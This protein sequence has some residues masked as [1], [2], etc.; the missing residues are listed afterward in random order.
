MS[1]MKFNWDKFQKKVKQ[2]SEKKKGYEKDDRFWQPTRDPKKGTGSAIIRFIP[3]F[4]YADPF[5]KMFSHGFYFMHQ[6]RKVWW[7]QNCRTTLGEECDVCNKNFEYWNSAYES[8]KDIARARKR[9]TSFISN[10]LVIKDPANPDNEG[11]VFLY[12]FGAKIHGMIMKHWMPSDEDLEDPDFQQFVPFDPFEGANFKIKIKTIQTGEQSWPN[13][14][15]SSFSPPS[16]LLKGNEAKIQKLLDQTYDLGE[17]LAESNFPTVELTRTKLAPIL[18][19]KS[20]LEEEEE[21]KPEKD[22]FEEDSDADTV[23]DSDD[24]DTDIDDDAPVEEEPAEP[25]QPVCKGCKEFEEECTCN[26]ADA[27]PSDEEDEDLAFFKNLQ[28][29]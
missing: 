23:D 18:G 9:R 4:K 24:T 28:A 15:D 8:D 17:F 29:D 1:K 16:P 26:D 7:I 20:T 5:I 25:E 12:Q 22:F 6:N 19:V 13:Y 2:E 10:I 27:A 21:P 3:T 14:D 11:K